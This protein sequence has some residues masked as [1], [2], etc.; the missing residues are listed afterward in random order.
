MPDI[1]R[2]VE[3]IQQAYFDVC[4]LLN[5]GSYTE[6]GYENRKDFLLV[7]QEH[8]FQAEMYLKDRL[9]EE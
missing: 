5:G 4:D 7:M 9:T 1:N 2:A 8:L 3:K 6:I